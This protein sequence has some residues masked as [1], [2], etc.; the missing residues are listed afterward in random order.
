MRNDLV[1]LTSIETRQRKSRV[2]DL[3]F[4]LCVAGTS[5]VAL[6]TF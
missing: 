6:M 5:L 2:R 3:M 1:H 4:A